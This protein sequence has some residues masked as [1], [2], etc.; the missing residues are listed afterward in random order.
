MRG[1]RT[2]GLKKQFPSSNARRWSGGVEKA[3]S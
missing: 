2:L 3:I 1:V